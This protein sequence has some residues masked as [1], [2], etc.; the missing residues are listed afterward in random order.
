[1]DRLHGVFETKVNVLYFHELPIFSKM[2]TEFENQ[3]KIRQQFS[4]ITNLFASSL[5]FLFLAFD[6]VFDCLE[7]VLSDDLVNVGTEERY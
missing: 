1:M 3:Q 4:F 5:G 2:N 6:D 7:D